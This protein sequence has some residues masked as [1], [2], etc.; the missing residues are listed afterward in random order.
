MDWTKQLDNYC[1]RLGPEFW[2]E[3]VNAVTNVAFIVAAILALRYAVRGGRLDWPL[4]VLIAI[5]AA[6]GIGSF[7]FHTYA[8][9]WAVMADVIPI[10]LFIVAYFALAMRRFAG[11]AWWLAGL[12]TA[13][14]M[15]VS[16]V[17]GDALGGLVGERLNGSEGYIPPLVALIVVGAILIAAGRDAAG[18]ALVTAGALFAVSLSFRTADMAVCGAF[19]LGTHFMWHTLNGVLLGYLLYAMIR[20]GRPAGSPEVA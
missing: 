6:V 13:A 15:G 20:H 17:G 16:F 11:L 10:Q 19:P 4:G 14:F 8:T 2:A 9:V 1:E 3:P 5:T 7:L 12:A 18:W